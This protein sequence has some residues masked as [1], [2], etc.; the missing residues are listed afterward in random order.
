MVDLSKLKLAVYLDE[1]AEDPHQSCGKLAAQNIKH[2]CVRNIW[3]SNIC[4]LADEACEMLRS[5]IDKSGLSVALVCSNV[6]DTDVTKMDG[7]Y[8]K[9]DRAI[10]VC[11]YLGSKHLKVS[12]GRAVKSDRAARA[13]E[14]WMQAVSDLTLGD[15]VMPVFELS[16]TNSIDVPA[17]LAAVLGKHLR[18]S[19]I[20]DPAVLIMH[21]NIDPFTKYWS[22]L[23]NRVSHLDIHDYK[24]GNSPRPP[25]H[26][27]AKLDITINDAISSGFR[28]WYCL[29]PGLGRRH[30]D[31]ITKENTFDYSYKALVALL[32]RIDVGVGRIQK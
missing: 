12:I 30:G 11:K 19:I 7:E 31:V 26:G 27:D 14:L 24:I 21:R 13:T 10:D 29:E 23:K 15:D 32:D 18:W 20:Y 6:G 5:S 17:I 28:G 2:V 1:V 3:S 9:L 25:G 16:H 4:S 8:D 22:L